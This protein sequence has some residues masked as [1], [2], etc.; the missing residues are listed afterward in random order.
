[1]RL[2]LARLEP[3]SFTTDPL[4]SAATKAARRE[5]AEK[6]IIDAMAEHDKDFA[7]TGFVSIFISSL[8]F[9]IQRN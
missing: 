5:T 9:A 2:T 4:A 1:M 8:N 3:D 7:K 6:K